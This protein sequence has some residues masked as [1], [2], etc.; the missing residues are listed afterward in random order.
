M[1]KENL[2]EVL[3]LFNIQ[4]HYKAMEIETVL[5]T[6]MEREISGAER[7]SKKRPE[8]QKNLVCDK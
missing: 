6:A 3:T 7:Q 1:S 5:C 2:G 4:W 8:D